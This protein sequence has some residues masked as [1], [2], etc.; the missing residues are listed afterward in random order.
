LIVG[1]AGSAAVWAADNGAISQL[2]GAVSR[3]GAALGSHHTARA[4]GLS[5]TELKRKRCK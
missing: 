4:A 5:S 2:I 1:T 3:D